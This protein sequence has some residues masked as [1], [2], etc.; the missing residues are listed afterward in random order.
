MRYI[1]E[2]SLV[3][4][5]GLR[6]A[7]FLIGKVRIRKYAG[8][9]TLESLSKKHVEKSMGSSGLWSWEQIWLNLK[10]PIIPQISPISPF[11]PGNIS[12]YL[13]V[14]ATCSMGTLLASIH[15]LHHN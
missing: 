10:V 4:I 11:W 12:Q 13:I 1:F 14:D 8:L 3:D 2:Y 6:I 15:C 5:V 9:S 7:F